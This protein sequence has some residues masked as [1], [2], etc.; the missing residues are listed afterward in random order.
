MSAFHDST[1]EFQYKPLDSADSIRILLLHPASASPASLHCDLIYTT[2]SE[3]YRDLFEYFVALS[4]VW[5]STDD[6]QTIFL[7]GCHFQI[8]RNLS[9]ALHNIREPNRTVRLWADAIC[10][11]QQDVDERNQQV[12]LIGQIFSIAHHTIIY[13]GPSTL[14]ISMAFQEAAEAD[15]KITSKESVKPGE[16][17]SNDNGA[18]HE[19]HMKLAAG[20]LLARA[21]FT[22]IWVFQEVVL[23][24]DPWVQCGKSRLT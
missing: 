15:W 24:K 12:A 6:L 22:R 17:Y 3:C 19:G 23:S 20:D 10:I 4:Y 16:D 1:S 13:L 14:V 8:T 2:I 18:F 5:G 9:E 21:W 11:N 7:E